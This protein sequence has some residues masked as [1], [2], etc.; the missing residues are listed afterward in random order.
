MLPTVLYATPVSLSVYHNTGNW[1]CH[2]TWKQEITPV[3]SY[4][5]NTQIAGC[6]SRPRLSWLSCYGF[7]QWLPLFLHY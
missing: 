6:H 1:S 2:S 5:Q 7:L 4:I 3:C